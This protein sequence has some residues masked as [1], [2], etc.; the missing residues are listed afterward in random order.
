MIT[1]YIYPPKALVKSQDTRIEDGISKKYFTLGRIFNFHI[2]S[3]A[4]YESPSN[5]PQSFK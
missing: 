4:T 1:D 3:Q 5:F 2:A